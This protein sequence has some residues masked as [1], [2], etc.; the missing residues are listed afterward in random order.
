MQNRPPRK[1][2]PEQV[3]E[4]IRLKHYSLKAERSYVAWI[5]RFILFHGIWRQ[6]DVDFVP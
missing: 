5:D 6:R 3:G 4:K 2:L 1:K